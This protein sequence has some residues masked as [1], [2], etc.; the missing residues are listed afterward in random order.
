MT[1]TK[2]LPLSA[3]IENPDALRV[4]DRD[5]EEYQNLRASIAERGVVQAVS[6]RPSPEGDGRY[7]LIDGAHRYTAAKDV[8]LETIRAQ[9]FEMDDME[10]YE[11]QLVTNLHQVKTRPAEYAQQLNRMLLRDPFLT[12]P[13]LAKRLGASVAWLN[14]RLKLTTLIKDAQELVDSGQIS[15]TNG[16]QLARLPEEE[17]PEWVERAMTMAPDEFRSNA[18]ERVKAIRKAKREGRDPDAVT[19]WQPTARIR[20]SSELKAVHENKG[21]VQS[22]I[23]SISDP[24]EA[25]YE[26]L[27]WVL[28]LDD[29]SV[30]KQ[31]AAEEERKAALEKARAKSKLERAKKR[32][33]AAAAAQAEAEAEAAEAGIA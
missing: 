1:E 4:V 3:I 27:K 2:N 13:Q 24:V 31:K 9:V 12:I 33:E 15:V 14:G 22:I 11:T 29:A 18:N 26:V 21:A 32:R 30:E 17:Q 5:R 23:G 28:Q 10:A 19:E 16:T 20:K 7:I 25:G 8:G 6:V